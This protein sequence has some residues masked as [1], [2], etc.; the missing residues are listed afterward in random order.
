MLSYLG[1]EEIA[2]VTVSPVAN[3]Q[4]PEREKKRDSEMEDEKNKRKKQWMRR[5]RGAD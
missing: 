3:I 4:Q 5:K 1:L 2:F